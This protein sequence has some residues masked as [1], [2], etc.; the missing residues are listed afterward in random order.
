MSA[1]D[2]LEEFY[3]DIKEICLD[4]DFSLFQNDEQ[5]V[6][7]KKYHIILTLIPLSASFKKENPQADMRGIFEM[8]KSYT[9]NKIEKVLFAS[10]ME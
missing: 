2:F 8:T 1:N 10:S 5:N 9:L 3:H 7:S 4:E 6:H